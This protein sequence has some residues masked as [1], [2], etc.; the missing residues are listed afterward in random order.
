MNEKT[1]LEKE[2]EEVHRT[3]KNYGGILIFL[4]LLLLICG[5]YVVSLQ[6]KTFDLNNTIKK[7][8]LQVDTLTLELETE[9]LRANECLKALEGN[10]KTTDANTK[11][12]TGKGK[13]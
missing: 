6:K 5:F 10:K 9:R 7:L 2:L 11:N 1:K 3:G 12:T 4:L 8:Q 13:P